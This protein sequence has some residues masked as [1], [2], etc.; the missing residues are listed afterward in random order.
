MKLAGHRIVVVTL[1]VNNPFF[2]N[3]KRRLLVIPAA[4]VLLCSGTLISCVPKDTAKVSWEQDKD[5]VIRS[6]H[7]IKLGQQEAEA[8]SRD[9]LTSIE[10][11]MQAHE[12]VNA[13]QQQEI[14]SLLAKIKI[15]QAAEKKDAV[16]KALG[17]KKKARLAIIAARRPVAVEVP[18]IPPVVIAKPKVTTP[19][20]VEAEKNAYT[21]AYL[22]LK[23]GRFEEASSAFNA[24]LD[25][26]PQG[27]YSDQ[28]W[29]WLGET[30]FAQHDLEK[31]QHAFKYVVDRYAKS[32]KYAAALLKLGQI[33]ESMNNNDKAFAYYQ[34]LVKE[35]GDSVVA[36][37]ARS[38]MAEL[39]KTRPATAVETR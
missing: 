14:E 35:R 1:S 4:V 2:V 17:A 38:R 19:A 29:Y 16:K 32:A 24:Q 6:V 34:R 25:K 21:A 36:E 3:G 30:R 9:M 20:E 12:E 27:E 28:A 13:K 8:F 10:E 15:L 11:R 22:A 26:Y 31:A 7:D 37:Q 18:V 23:S 33:S 39:N 5:T